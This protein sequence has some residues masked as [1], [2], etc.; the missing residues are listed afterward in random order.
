MWEISKC[1]EW[2]ADSWFEFYERPAL[3]NSFESFEINDVD[4]PEVNKQLSNGDENTP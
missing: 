4:Y 3:V 1:I 2:W